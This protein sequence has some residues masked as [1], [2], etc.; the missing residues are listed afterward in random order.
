MMSFLSHPPCIPQAN[1]PRSLTFRT[2]FIM[3]II[4]SQIARYFPLNLNSGDSKFKLLSYLWN[5]QL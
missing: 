4:F 1:T 5:Y 3:L 2:M